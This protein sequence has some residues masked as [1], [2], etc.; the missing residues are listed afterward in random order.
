MLQQSEM[1]WFNTLTHRHTNFL[2]LWLTGLASLGWGQASLSLGEDLKSSE[3]IIDPQIF[4]KIHV[5]WFHKEEWDCIWWTH[6][7]LK[8]DIL[9][10]ILQ[11]DKKCLCKY[12]SN[13]PLGGEGERFLFTVCFLS[14]QLPR[15]CAYNNSIHCLKSVHK[16]YKIK[17]TKHRSLWIRV[18]STL[19]QILHWGHLDQAGTEKQN[20]KKSVNRCQQ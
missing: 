9:T 12:S 18:V 15:L 4:Y 20:H 6:C 19:P 8:T 13:V 3:T 5:Y 11:H 16:Q 7:M 10:N 17:S 2:P 1:C 14:V